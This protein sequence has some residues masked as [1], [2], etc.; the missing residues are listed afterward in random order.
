MF[1]IVFRQEA[2]DD[3]I[4]IWHNIDVTHFDQSMNTIT[5]DGSV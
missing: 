4:D 1:K 5:I 2:I 3:L